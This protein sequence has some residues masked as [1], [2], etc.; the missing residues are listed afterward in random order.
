MEPFRVGGNKPMNLSRVTALAAGIGIGVSTIN[1]AQAAFVMTL[2]DLSTAGVDVVLSDGLGVGATTDSGLTTTAAD[3]GIG[4]DG[5]ISF[6]GGV[7]SF[8]VNVVTGVSDP[9]LGP[10]QLDLN[11]INVTG[12]S[13][14]LK[15]GLTDTGYTG[16]VPAYL[17][18]FGG[19]TTGSITFDF[20]HD[21]TNSE[22]GGSSISPPTAVGAGPFS[23]SVSGAVGAGSPYSL[24]IFADIVHTGGG[25]S[26]SFN[27]QMTPVPVPAAVWLFGSGLVGLVGV[28][29]RR[30]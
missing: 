6:N 19:T 12:A 20:R 24:T 27:V 10:G 29:R 15:I 18:D 5:F 25:Q 26:S 13:G 30:S 4:S 28:A 17:A 8:V 16:T 14:N 7:G 21:S 23:G 22:F 11:S 2:D 1:F 9:L 3:S